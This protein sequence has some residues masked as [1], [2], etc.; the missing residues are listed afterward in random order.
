MCARVCAYFARMTEQQFI[1]NNVFF[2]IMVRECGPVCWNKNE[3]FASVCVYAFTLLPGG[4]SLHQ[5]RVLPHH[6]AFI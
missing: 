2:L 3:L 1:N 6:G 5:Q 4:G